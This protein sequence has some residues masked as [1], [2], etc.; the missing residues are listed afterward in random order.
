MPVTRFGLV[1]VAAQQFLRQLLHMA[2][3]RIFVVN[4]DGAPAPA[5]AENERRMDAFKAYDMLFELFYFAS[6]RI[7][8]IV[9]GLNGLN[10]SEQVTLFAGRAQALI[11]MSVIMGVVGLKGITARY[12]AQALQ[13]AAVNDDLNVKNWVTLVSNLYQLGNQGTSRETQM[14]ISALEQSYESLGDRRRWGEARSLHCL[15]YFYDAQYERNIELA[16][17]F[18][19]RLQRTNEMQ[20]KV[21]ALQ[22]QSRSYVIMGR[23]RETI[24]ALTEAKTYLVHNLDQASETTVTGLLAR[25]Y[26]QAGEP[27]KAREAIE[28][29]VQ[30]ILT[31]SLTT[32]SVQIGFESITDTML[33]MLEEQSAQGQAIEAPLLEMVKKVLIASQRFARSFPFH[34]ASV[35]RSQGGYA[36][37]TGKPKAARAAWQKS[38][39][40]ARHYQMAYEEGMALFELGR[41][42]DAKERHTQLEQARA[43][44]EKIGAS[45]DLQRIP[46]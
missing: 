32:F 31:A 22:G 42:T 29:G 39:E 26:W 13:I 25:A 9:T 27:A 6:D 33:A 16:T 23:A 7:H 12:Q 19:V 37:L 24:A 11:G 10:I 38:L 30:I 14:A 36:W 41:H 43:I 45:Y 4:P 21:W 17:D 34:S 35:Y 8:L 44:L 46:S 18:Y 1:L 15:S 40:I 20:Q 2:F 3:P 28:Y 5:P